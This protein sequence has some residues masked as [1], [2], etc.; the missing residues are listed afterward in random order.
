VKYFIYKK[1]VSRNPFRIKVNT[2][3]SFMLTLV[4]NDFDFEMTLTLTF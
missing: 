3:L 2:K 4:R 1:H